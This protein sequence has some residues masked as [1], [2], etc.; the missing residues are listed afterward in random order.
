VVVVEAGEVVELLK[1]GAVVVGAVVVGTVVVGAIVEA[2]VV[3]TEG[4][5]VVAT[6]VEVEVVV[7]VAGTPLV[8]NERS[9]WAAPRICAGSAPSHPESTDE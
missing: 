1:P 9:A 7:V 2:T 3:A 6:I 8:N 5:T 4:A